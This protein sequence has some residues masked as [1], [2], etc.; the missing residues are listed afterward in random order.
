MDHRQKIHQSG[1]GIY[2][3]ILTAGVIVSIAVL[4]ILLLGFRINFIFGSLID[5]ATK[6]KLSVANAKFEFYKSSVD[7]NKTS[8]ISVWEHLSLA[9]LYAGK[10]FEE[11]DTFAVIALPLHKIEIQSKVQK[12]QAALFN[13][14]G[15]TSQLFKRNL[16][17]SPEAELLFNNIVTI[18]EEIELDL[19]TILDS[20][21]KVF[22]ISLFGLII[23]CVLFPF[24]SAFIFYRYEKQRTSFIKQI[25]N[26]TLTLEKGLHKKTRVEEAL[27]ETQRQLT[28]LIQNLPGMVYRCK[29]DSDWTMEFVSEKSYQLTGYRPNELINNNVVSY[30]SL[31]HPKDKLK[32]WN[33]IQKSV[34]ERK[35]FQLVYRIKTSSGYEKW[36]WEEGVGIFSETDDELIALEGFITDITEQKISEDQLQLQSNALEAAANGIVITDK[37]TNLIWANSAF[38]NI[39]GYSKSDFAENKTNVF[40]SD[41]H[42]ISFFENLWDTIKSGE[43]W[44]GEMI[45]KKKDGSTY[46]QEMTITPIRNSEKQI[47]YFVAIIQDITERKK[48]E[49]ALRESEFRFRGLYEN[50]TVGIY[51]TSLSGKILMANPTLL[52]ILG[53]DTLD[54]LSNLQAKDAYVEANTREVFARELNLK[55]K[56]FGFESRWKKKDGTIIYVRESA[57]L[58]KDDDERPIFYEG[59]VEDITD[60]KIAEEQLISAKERAEQSDQLK[61]EFL[62][63]MSHEIRTPLN[64]ILSF[65][66]MMKDELHDKVDE[67][68]KK[69]FDVIDEEGKRIMRTI[70][71]I[72]NMSELQTGNY[73]FKAREIDLNK[74]IL[75]KH[76]Q[77][78][79]PIASQKKVALNLIKSVDNTTVYADE[80]S[81]NQ[82]FYHLID[83]A[84]KFTN[85]GKVEIDL[86]MD[87][88]NNI[89]VDVIDTGIGISEEY[90]KLLFTP[91]TKEEKGYTRNYE[92]NGLGLALVKKYCDLNN[93]EIKVTSQK[94]KGSI[95]RVTFLKKPG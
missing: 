78:Y 62:A 68:L 25:E 50:A 1:K 89:Y 35:T 43:I 83:N 13:Y 73:N 60:K 48:S 88:R 49:D 21:I 74:N 31:I 94:G 29:P 86:N 77:N 27:Q 22:R 23:F 57:R 65:T 2:F 82:I 28:T 67:E 34:E 16:K 56:V 79:Q 58:V 55:N 81:V 10:L 92:G 66:G 93:A 3:L 44:R 80:Y 12:L 54:E 14:R 69:G 52:R 87:P 75:S 91:F 42:D 17:T 85:T 72:I 45:N 26:A 36:V 33:Q 9:E 38:W 37:N 32:I 40:K 70:E 51:R 59:T 76:F 47:I 71:L 15:E 18:S 95:F 61:S 30:N 84:I 6:V 7:T 4:Y 41:F 5:S 39:T 63:Q 11:K 46:F 8:L 19:R 20:E 64:V 53:Y 90:M 24:V